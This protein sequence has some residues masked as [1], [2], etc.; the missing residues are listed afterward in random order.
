MWVAANTSCRRYSGPHRN[1]IVPA[2]GGTET[3]GY[4]R[5]ALSSEWNRR[6]RRIAG[7]VLGGTLLW[8]LVILISTSLNSDREAV[9][10]ESVMHWLLPLV[11]AAFVLWATCAIVLLTAQW[12]VSKDMGA[13]LVSAAAVAGVWM[14][15][16]VAAALGVELII[17]GSAVAVTYVV[18]GVVWSWSVLAAPITTFGIVIVAYFWSGLASDPS[19][20]VGYELGMWEMGAT[21]TGIVIG[22][23]VA[24]VAL[25]LAVIGQWLG[26]MLHDRLD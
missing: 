16:T 2:T 12:P 20:Y 26:V 18:M 22:P 7:I 11:I 19:I 3:L 17:I 24:L 13:A 5:I 21:V 23:V 9:L 8:A 25:I 14:L 6:L 10:S 15:A 1:R 4:D